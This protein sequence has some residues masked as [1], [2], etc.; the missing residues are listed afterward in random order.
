M[1]SGAVIGEEGK[2]TKTEL[3]F[4]LKNDVKEM[5]ETEKEHGEKIEKI[6]KYIKKHG[7]PA[8]AVEGVKGL[9]EAQGGTISE[10]ALQ[11]SGL[12][13]KLLD[14]A[15]ARERISYWIKDNLG[16][17][18]ERVDERISR[19]AQNVTATAAAGSRAAAEEAMRAAGTERRKMRAELEKTIA[20]SASA[21]EQFGYADRITHV[22]TGGGAS[23]EFF[24]GHELP[25]V[26]CL[27]DA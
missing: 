24:A 1:A 21:C 20:D 12:N 16:P 8:A 4:T 18:L 7:N 27:L 13:Q 22:S 3:L 17:A 5:K 9:I 26:S 11:L 14:E 19:S 23:L 10:Q 15:A 6:I 2:R 25:G